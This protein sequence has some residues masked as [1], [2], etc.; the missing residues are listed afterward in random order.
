MK[1]NYIK[2][3][4]LFSLILN[5]ACQTETPVLEVETVVLIDGTDELKEVPEFE[6]F[7]KK[8]KPESQI[9]SSIFR[10][11]LINDIE[12]SGINQIELKTKLT[13]EETQEEIYLRRNQF[14]KKCKEAYENQ[15]KSVTEK[16]HSII[17]SVV[18]KQLNILSQSTASQRAIYL[19]SDLYENSDLLNVYNPSQFKDLKKNKSKY[20]QQFESKYPLQNLNGIEVYFLYKPKDFDDNMKYKELY[21]L[22]ISILTNKG[23]KCITI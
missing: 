4:V 21:E 13:N 22:Y 3:I 15:L 6:F 11:G 10:C 7:K 2:M 5:N 1:K 14:I 16:D 17:F 12:F 8:I 19:F 18:V 9:N 23:A 20:I